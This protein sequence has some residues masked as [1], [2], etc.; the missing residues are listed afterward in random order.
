MK[1]FSLVVIAIVLLLLISVPPTYSMLKSSKPSS[2][3]LSTAIWDVAMTEGNDNELTIRAKEQLNDSYTFKVS[4]SSE[5]D[6]TYDVIISNVPDKV[7]VKLDDGEFLGTETGEITINNA[8]T[9]LYGSGDNE[10]E[11]TL[12]FKALE[13]ATPVVDTNIGLK[14]VISQVLN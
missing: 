6:V 1:K 3:V 2:A 5:V 9:I 4:S 8:G 13:G 7:Q 11:H 10:N 14:V 12:T